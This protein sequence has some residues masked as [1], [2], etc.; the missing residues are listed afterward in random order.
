MN[1]WRWIEYQS[2]Y[3]SHWE[4]VNSQSS[5][6]WRRHGNNRIERS[7][8]SF[9][10]GQEPRTFSS[11]TLSFYHQY[12]LQIDRASCG[13]RD[14]RRIKVLWSIVLYGREPSFTFLKSNSA[15]PGILRATIHSLWAGA[16]IS[17]FRTLTRSSELSGDRLEI[18][19]FIVCSFMIE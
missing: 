11:L 2:E 1:Y 10:G 8:D 17:Y 12:D 3:C 13:K 5:A 4:Q 16:L 9:F 6:V 19:Q 18:L 7:Y 14:I 15:V